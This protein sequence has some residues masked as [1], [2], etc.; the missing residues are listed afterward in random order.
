[1]RSTRR[2]LALI[3]VQQIMVEIAIALSIFVYVIQFVKSRSNPPRR[4]RPRRYT[5]NSRISDQVRNLHR[6]VVVGNLRMDHNAFGRM[7]YILE[8]SGGLLGTKHV[9]VSEQVVMFLSVISHQKKNCIVEHGFITYGRTV[10]KHFHAVLNTISKMHDIF[11][12]KPPAI[13]ADYLDPRWRWFKVLW[14]KNSLTIEYPNTKKAD[15]EYGKDRLQSI[16]GVCNLNMQFLYVLSGC[17]GSAADS[18]VLRDAIHQPNGLQ[19]LSELEILDPADR[20][21]VNADPNVEYILTINVSTAWTTS[22]DE[23]TFSMYNE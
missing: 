23:L 11:L 19:V 7:C 17:D 16:L 18:R 21:D 20:P 9:T 13:T 22:R 1:M 2:I 3:V 14:M 4:V 8:H 5:C 15:I 6:L 12:A 10:S